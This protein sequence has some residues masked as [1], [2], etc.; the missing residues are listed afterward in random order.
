[1]NK[2]L[3]FFFKFLKKKLLTGTK[4]LFLVFVIKIGMAIVIGY[5]TRRLILYPENE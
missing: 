5:I 2:N 3:K 1:M 4:A